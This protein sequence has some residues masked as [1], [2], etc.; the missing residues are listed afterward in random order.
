M[1][2]KWY[3]IIVGI[4]LVLVGLDPWLPTGPEIM[5]MPTAGAI[6]IIVGVVGI[7]LGLMELK[8]NKKGGSAQPTS[9][10][11]PPTMPAGQ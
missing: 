8:A 2:S 10:P 5:V 3:T 1:Y 6:A 9:S 4:A 7:L 11:Q